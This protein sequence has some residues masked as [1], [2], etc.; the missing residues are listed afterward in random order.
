MNDQDFLADLDLFSD[1]YKDEYGFRPRGFS[2]EAALAY[3]KGRKAREAELSARFARED[4]EL[5][6]WLD[7]R[8]KTDAEEERILDMQCWGVDEFDDLPYM[9]QREFHHARR[10]A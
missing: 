10:R 4:E 3:L 6:E 9:A 7:H 2:E 1:L 5:R 8:E